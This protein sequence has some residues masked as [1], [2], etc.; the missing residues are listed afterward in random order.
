MPGLTRHSTF[1]RHS[2]LNKGNTLTMALT[3]KTGK[4][5]L[6]ANVIVRPMYPEGKYLARLDDV[7]ISSS[8]K[9]ADRFK[10]NV[11]EEDKEPKFQWIFKGKKKDK[12]G[13]LTDLIVD[14][15]NP[16]TGI[17]KAYPFEIGIMTGT[18]FGGKRA[19]LT[20][21][22]PHIIAGH[23]DGIPAKDVT[24]ELV[25]EINFKQLVGSL[26]YI[27]IIED[28]GDDGTPRNKVVSVR[29]YD[30]GDA[31]SFVDPADKINDDPM[32]E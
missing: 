1:L 12:N 10:P 7:L 3:D 26:V 27:S 6:K 28:E 9:F 18:N 31:V 2:Y 19:T 15:K 20:K 32:G 11:A 13:V 17:A 29:A 14:V 16:K 22:L 23:P 21:Y 8:Q 30:G 4:D 24:G 25:A 5:D